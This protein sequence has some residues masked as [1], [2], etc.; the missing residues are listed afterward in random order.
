M[1]I[2]ES[3][4]A[5]TPVIASKTGIMQDIIVHEQNGLHFEVGNAQ[6]LREAIAYF[7]QNT[8]SHSA[9]CERARESYEASYTPQQNFKQLYKAYTAVMHKSTTE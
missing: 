6:S 7:E 9:Y 8:Q 5:A 3:F 2:L 4:A 1:V